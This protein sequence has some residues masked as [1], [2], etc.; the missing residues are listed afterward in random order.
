M[1]LVVSI[2]VLAPL[3]GILTLALHQPG[4]L[5][6]GLSV[7]ETWNWG[8]FSYA[9]D[10]GH[11]STHFRSSVIVAVAVVLLATTVSILAGY[12]FGTMKFR[13][14]DQLFLVTLVGLIMPFEVVIVPLYYDLRA[15]RL[16]N[17]YLSLVLPETALGCTFGIFWMRAYFRSVPR[18]LLDA[19]R[20]DGASNMT[21]LV[22]VLLPAG[23]PAILTLLLLLFLGSWNEFLLPLVM[24]Q[25]ESHRTLPLALTF[26]SQQYTSDRPSQA[27]AALIVAAP[28]VL[29]YVFLQRHFIR[30]ML[31][32]AIKG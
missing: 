29:L 30:G 7:P 1:L 14:R 20:V 3:A 23:R 32:G 19:A 4:E 27:A 28:I 26:F 9:W 17:T 24:I 13:G 16:D 31:S 11:F 8:T 15:L 25:D 5:V 10:T 22:R 2:T 18:S 21:I 6:S 12:A